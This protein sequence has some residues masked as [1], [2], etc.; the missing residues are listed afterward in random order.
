[1][2][3]Y[4]HGHDL[5]HNDFCNTRGCGVKTLL[6]SKE[7]LLKDLN[8]SSQRLGTKKAFC[9]PFYSS[10]SSVRKTVE[11]AGFQVAFGGGNRSSTMND[12]KYLLPRF[13]IYYN[14]SVDSL[15]KMLTN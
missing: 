9:Y 13:V 1:M 12:N 3:V 11:E 5:H 7:E 14:T 4:S 6:L 15:K 2:E 8:T 10:N